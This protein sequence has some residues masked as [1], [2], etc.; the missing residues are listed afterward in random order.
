MILEYFIQVL[1]RILDFLFPI[2]NIPQIGFTCI[3]IASYKPVAGLSAF[4]QD[5]SSQKR[6]N[7]PEKKGNSLLVRT[8]SLRVLSEFSEYFRMVK[9]SR[10][11]RVRRRQ[12][13]IIKKV[14][15]LIG[16]TS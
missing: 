7:D 8:A 15:P 5:D 16:G 9:L 6:K 1:I 12:S 13:I 2:S 4:M 10:I 3:R 11:V 14:P